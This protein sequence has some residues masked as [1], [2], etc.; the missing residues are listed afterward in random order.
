MLEATMGTVT[1][2]PIPTAGVV[3]A[4]DVTAVD[5]AAGVA[6][7][8]RQRQLPAQPPQ[9]DGRRT[10]AA[11]WVVH[12]A[13]GPAHRRGGAG[14]GAWSRGPLRHRAAGRAT[15]LPAGCDLRVVP[16]ATH[17]FAEP[18]SG[19]PAVAHC[20]VG[21]VR[22]PRWWSWWRPWPGAALPG[23]LVNR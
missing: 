13:G 19:P 8:P 3:L 12:G 9:P 14:R 21:P 17:L 2:V 20:S 11:R 4:G 22:W 15:G 1:A 5:Q 18:P 10:A 7:R 6:V 16:H 23:R